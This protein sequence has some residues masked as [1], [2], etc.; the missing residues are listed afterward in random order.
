MKGEVKKERK[1]KRAAVG[2]EKKRGTVGVVKDF[3]K[4]EQTGGGQQKKVLSRL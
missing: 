3:D 2:E 4:R 1:G